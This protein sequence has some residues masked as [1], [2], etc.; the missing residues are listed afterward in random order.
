MYTVNSLNPDE[1]AAD[2]KSGKSEREIIDVRRPGEYETGHVKGSELFCL[3]NFSNPKNLEKLSPEKPYY[4][5]CAG[6]YRSVI[7][8]S[9]LKA[10]GFTNIVNVR[11]GWAGIK[12]QDL[13]LELPE[14]A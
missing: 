5:H 13:P 3:T 14:L 4:L 2:V 6:G 1:F 8:T 10:K 12:T 11:K 9:I 7:A